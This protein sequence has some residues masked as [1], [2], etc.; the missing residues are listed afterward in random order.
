MRR[1][2]FLGTLGVGALPVGLSVTPAEV[3]IP[4]HK[5]D[6][7]EF[8][9]GPR[10]EPRQYQGPFPQ[11]SPEQ[12]LEGSEVVMATTPSRKIVPNF[13]MGLVVYVSGD[14]GPPHIA[15]EPLGKSI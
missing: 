5:W 7:F 2:R 11:Y 9:G 14:I 10:L 13:G 12:F 4:G 3:R 8:G 6:G 1:R 15:G